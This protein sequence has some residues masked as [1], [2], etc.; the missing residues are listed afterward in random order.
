MRRRSASMILRVPYGRVLFPRF[1][2][3]HTHEFLDLRCADKV[4]RNDP[5]PQVTCFCASSLNI[6]DVVTNAP[7]GGSETHSY[8]VAGNGIPIS[9]S[10]VPTPSESVP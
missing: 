4:H 9:Q 5:R 1:L 6:I 8:R 3:D 7:S 10:L 2:N